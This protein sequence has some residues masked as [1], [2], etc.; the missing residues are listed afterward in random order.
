[1]ELEG[2]LAAAKD[3]RKRFVVGDDELQVDDFFYEVPPLGG[4][5]VVD[6]GIQRTH[7]II[8]HA[9]CVYLDCRM[10]SEMSVDEVI[11]VKDLDGYYTSYIH[12]STRCRLSSVN[13]DM[14]RISEVTLF[15]VVSQKGKIQL[16]TYFQK[17]ANS[18]KNRQWDRIKISTTK[19]PGADNYKLF[20]AYIRF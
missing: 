3:F 9:G 6:R 4:D 19:Q 10:F 14:E 7:W 5:E 12:L 2:E 15:N 8:R 11:S 16:S 18:L 20:E 17:I 13:R 1:M